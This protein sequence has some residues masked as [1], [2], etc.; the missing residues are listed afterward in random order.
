M[1]IL[2]LLLIGALQ[3]GAQAPYSFEERQP[4]TSLL[5]DPVAGQVPQTISASGL[6][7][8][9]A[10]RTPAP[11]LIPYGVNS[12]L[13]SDGAVKTRFI[14][15]PGESQIEFSADGIWKFPPNAVLVKNFYTGW[16]NRYLNL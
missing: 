6:F 11:G 14:A 7:S 10:A 3:T 15:L 4:N 1:Y 9:M 2:L 16:A 13:W 5:I 12:V 8:D